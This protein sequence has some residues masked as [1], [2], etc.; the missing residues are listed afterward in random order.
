MHI[1][2]DDTYGPIGTTTSAYVTGARRTHVAVIFRDDEVSHIRELVGRCL[3]DFTSLLPSSPPEFHFTDIYNRKGIWKNLEGGANLRIFEAFA[4][5]YRQHPWKVFTQTIDNRTVADHPGL[6]HMPDIDGLD[7]ENRAD[8]SL[9]LLCLK[10]R[11]AFTPVRPAIHLFV[12]QGKR[13]PGSPF[14]QDLFADWGSDFS[15]QFA[16]SSAEPLLQ[17]AD[18]LAF[19]INRMTH[20]SMKPKRTETDDWLVHL[21]DTM[22]INCE[23]LQKQNPPV[24]FTV[25]YFDRLHRRDRRK[26]GL[27]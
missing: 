27:E 19:L 5:I 8:L 24:V 22:N 10:L 4:D 20:L 15:G 7:P 1:A 21:V 26:K 6:L 17:I 13:S 11:A 23:Q 18:L 2:I 14:G 12:D 9:L 25:E 16:S 3:S